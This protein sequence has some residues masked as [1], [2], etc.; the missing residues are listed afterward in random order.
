M[1]SLP[2]TLYIPLWRFIPDT[3]RWF[4]RKG[5]IDAAVE[6]IQN[7]I[8]VNS[9][10]DVTSSELRQRLMNHTESSK[11]PPPAEWHTLWKDRRTLLQMIAIHIAWAV[12]VT[13]YNGMLL[14]VK[15]FG[16]EYLSLNTIALGKFV[17]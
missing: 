8:S 12:Y 4:L 9:K 5:Q 7:A 11:E 15:A 16:R 10:E 13:N 2:T 6:I 1:I 14:N 17:R 3:P